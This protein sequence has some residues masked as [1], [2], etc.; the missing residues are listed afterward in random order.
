MQSYKNS[1]L[2]NVLRSQKIPYGTKRENN[3]FNNFILRLNQCN[4]T[5]IKIRV[6]YFFEIKWVF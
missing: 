2:N 5:N 1:N 3:Y 4:L 6:N